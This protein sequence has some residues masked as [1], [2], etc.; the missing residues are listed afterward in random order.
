V[1]EN[2]VFHAGSCEP[3]ASAAERLACVRGVLFDLDG[4]L[5]DTVELIR[6]SFRHAT[7]EVLG[8]ALPD[9]L[10]MANVGQPLLTQFQDLVPERAEEL[11]R[12]YRVYN[13][14]HHDE[15]VREYP[16]TVETLAELAR[17]GLPMGVVTSKGTEGARRDLDYFGLSGFFPV[18]ISADDVPIHKPDPYPLRVA[19]ALLDVPLE[20]CVYVGDSPHD[21]QAAVSGGAIA[22]AALW[23]AF[24]ESD[25]LAPGPPFALHD[26]GEL[27]GLLFGD[28]G[29]CGAERPE[30]GPR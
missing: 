18:V 27:P 11:V 25:V 30:Q 1:E 4:T 24:T 6:M 17:R 28:A 29:G 7:R 21:M 2:P 12:V 19:A 23:G 10:T 16:R 5:V 14:A 3:L 26:I 15:L 9:S 22:V 13:Q 20:Y 8:E